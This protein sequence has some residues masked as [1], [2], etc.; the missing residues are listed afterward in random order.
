MPLNAEQDELLS[1]GIEEFN[2]REFYECHE[3][4]EE[5]WR[6]LAIEEREL[7]QGIIQAAVAYYHLGRDNRLGATRL[8]K[9]GLPRLERFLPSAL[10]LDLQ[11]FVEKVKV[12]LA[13]LE[14][15]PAAPASAFQIPRVEFISSA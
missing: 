2:R 15:D 10:G 12:D 3:T 4:L 1:R 8:L 9:R 5:L 6:P 7:V 14:S 13:L 11:P